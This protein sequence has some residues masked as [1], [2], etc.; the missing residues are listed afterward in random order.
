MDPN[1]ESATID[2]ENSVQ[3]EDLNVLIRWKKCLVQLLFSF[4]KEMRA[5][6]GPLYLYGTCNYKY[7]IERYGPGSDLLLK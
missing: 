1:W 3:D 4:E 2:C 5:E 6:Y 7:I